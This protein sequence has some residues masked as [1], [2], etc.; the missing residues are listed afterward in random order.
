MAGPRQNKE[1]SVD[2]IFG[3]ALTKKLSRVRM[4]ALR[5]SATVFLAAALGSQAV[6]QVSENYEKAIANL[7]EEDYDTALIHLKNAL[8]EDPN[9]LPARI[10]LGK[11]LYD[12][13][14]GVGA[15][16]QFQFALDAGADE[17]LVLVPMADALL[18]QAKFQDLLEI[19][20]PGNRGAEVEFDIAMARGQAYRALG[21]TNEAYLSFN[22]AQSIFPNRAE[23]LAELAK[24]RMYER[25]YDRALELAEDAIS[26][27][28]QYA[29]GWSTKGEILQAQ[30]ELDAALEAFST[31]IEVGPNLVNARIARASILLD[32]DRLE[33]A[34]A[35]LEILDENVVNH[36]KVNF[37]QGTLA[38]RLGDD[39][40]AVTHF[41][42]V[43]RI[44]EALTEPYLNNKPDLVLLGGVALINLDRFEEA[45]AFL[46]RYVSLA[47]A[48]HNGRRF[49]GIALMNTG[50]QARAARL[51]RNLTVDRPEDP[52]AQTLLGTAYLE[53][54]DNERAHRHLQEAVGL[55]PDSADARLN[56]GLARLALGSPE[57]AIFELVRAAQL[58]PLAIEPRALLVSA[59]MRGQ[60][61]DEALRVAQEIVERHDQYPFSHNLLGTVLVARGELEPAR[62]A[63][64]QALAF[65]SR[66]GPALI[67]LAGLDLAAEDFS[68]AR[69]YYSEV[70]QY[71]AKD[72][73]AMLGLAELSRRQND[74][75]AAL[76]WI[77]KAQQAAPDDPRPWEYLV[78]Q[79]AAAGDLEGALEAAQ[80]YS[81][82]HPDNYQFRNF[83]AQMLMAL[84]KPEEAASLYSQSVE[85]AENRAQALTNLAEA[86]VLANQSESAKYSLQRAIAFNEGYVPAYVALIGLQ[87]RTGE[88][89][90]A[91]DLADKLADLV[92]DSLFI[93][94]V[95]GEAYLEA[96]RYG[97]AVREFRKGLEGSQSRPLT[98]GL[99]RALIARG[100]PLEASQLLD[101]WLAENADDVG[102]WRLLGSS[103]IRLSDYAAAVTTYERVSELDPED[104]NALNN[105]AW[106][107]SRTGDPRALEVARRA[108]EA[109]PGSAAI[110]DTL[111]WILIN[112]GEPQE[113][114]GLL[115]EAQAKASLNPEIRYHLAVALDKLGRQAEAKRELEAAFNFA[116]DFPGSQAAQELYDR[117]KSAQD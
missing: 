112:E 63:F 77:D 3:S 37:L 44:L 79:R 101:G 116:S 33:E 96:R 110:A 107:Y 5:L 66:Y 94:R 53:M 85:T 52:L 117:L 39:D 15:Q 43:H 108:R 59:F 46:E 73:A 68:R 72:V 40:K 95:R 75:D 34:Q 92:P 1:V 65:D 88:L 8:K 35:D 9:Y 58:A 69:N 76:D 91:I 36:P 27:D 105:L 26:V 2:V 38:S 83:R 104:S 54:G 48:D 100:D 7:A 12:L 42:R 61:L 62:A 84:D 49:L 98:L 111:A 50:N 10:L 28:P 16:E 30:N 6:A 23:P 14:N 25:E 89:A 55:A 13:S 64:E 113:A 4:R 57:G 31:A 97:D 82:S 74:G 81:E 21:D 60:N 93:D 17:A 47:P 103:Q 22:S 19:I 24:L 109:A 80:T 70:L 56:L 29:G 102:A 11:T 78:R 115:R 87:A 45:I 41:E 67:N 99:T 114:L 20:R 71:D 18:L 106:L 90:A 51:F 86:Q 32:L